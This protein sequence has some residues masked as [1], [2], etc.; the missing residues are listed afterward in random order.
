MDTTLQ[1]RLAVSTDVPVI[2]GM[3]RELSRDADCPDELL[4]THQDWLH[5]LFG[6]QPPFTALVAELDKRIVGTLI[7]A[8]ERYPGW[9]L[10][11]IKVHELYVVPEL[12]RQRIATTLFNFLADAVRGSQVVLMQLN[13]RE[14]NPARKFYERIGFQQVPECLTYAMALP[15]LQ[16]LIKTAASLAGDITG[17]L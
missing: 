13:V 15:A 16:A 4:A 8:I 6:P 14:A 9:A 7:Y 17:F 12:R 2:A 3:I 5:D 11:A 10:P 1:I